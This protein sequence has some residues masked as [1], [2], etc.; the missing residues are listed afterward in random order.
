MSIHAVA[1]RTVGAIELLAFC[2]IGR[3]RGHF[4][5]NDPTACATYQKAL[6]LCCQEAF[7]CSR[8]LQSREGETC[9]DEPGSQDEGDSQGNNNCAASLH[10]VSKAESAGPERAGPGLV[11]LRRGLNVD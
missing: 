8:L 2:D 11:L 4:R 9:N 5:E 10:V 1:H 7:D 6:G 3:R